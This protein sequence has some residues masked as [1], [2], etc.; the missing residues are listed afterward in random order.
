LE[1]AWRSDGYGYLVAV[2]GGKATMYQTTKVSC[3]PD[4]IRTQ[5]A[6][7]DGSI[8]FSLLGQ[9]TAAFASK[10]KDTAGLRQDGSLGEVNFS[11]IDRLP[12]QCDAPAKS[13]PVAAFDI[14]YNSY[15]EHYPF[16]DQQK[17]D[18]PAIGDT[19]RAKVSAATTDEELVA[20]FADMI[21]PLGDAHTSL[22][23]GEKQL[24]GGLRSGSAIG[25]G[26]EFQ[27]LGERFAAATQQYLG[28][29]V[30]T[31]ANDYIAYGDL[32][33]GVGYLRLAAFSGYSTSGNSIDDQ[34]ELS[35][36][37]DEIFTSD[38]VSK[39]RG[40]VIDVR[41]NGGGSDE[42][43]LQVAG[44]LS[45]KAFVAYTKQSRNDPADP[46]KFTAPQ[47]FSVKPA[48]GPKFTGPVTVLTSSLTISA[49]E[50]FTQAM[51]SRTPT[52]IRIGGNTQGVFSD[53]L[54]RNLPGSTVMFGLPNEEFI[55]A[56]G[57]SFDGAG[58]PPDVCLPTFTEADLA[59]AKDPAM[60]KARELLLS[61]VA[62]AKVDITKAPAGIC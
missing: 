47:S 32:P 23:V 52:P 36:A 57:F 61:G 21:R 45:D 13:D 9:T 20:I 10:T 28:V 7:T 26:E 54:L 34:A 43:A 37:L 15:L 1:G 49:G 51:L 27:P 44:R 5:V 31:W 14:F 22:F 50:T 19:F 6:A 24:Y 11:R 42:L 12:E 18:W 48:S 3:F 39:L 40:L 29:D 53:V 46:K 17:V 56:Q 25:K 16:F 59:A 60:D 8:T 62:P 38:R 41:W 2:T 35:R 33:D 58:I 30:K 55:T 4:P